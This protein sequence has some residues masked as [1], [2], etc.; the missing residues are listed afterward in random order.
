MNE[1]HCSNQRNGYLKGWSFFCWKKYSKCSQYHE[2]NGSLYN[3]VC[4][5][6]SESARDSQHNPRLSYFPDLFLYV[7]LRVLPLVK[8]LHNYFVMGWFNCIYARLMPN[9]SLNQE[10][11]ST[12]NFIFR[13]FLA[14]P[15]SLVW[16]SYIN[17]RKYICNWSNNWLI[18]VTLMPY[19]GMMIKVT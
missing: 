15:K 4:R 16:V 11:S 13:C 3:E 8:L 7:N 17:S 14:N 5:W 2:S 6:S 12:L 10:V 9:I 19:Y 18:L 1:V